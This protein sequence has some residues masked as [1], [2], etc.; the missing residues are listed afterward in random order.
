VLTAEGTT[1]GTLSIPG[2]FTEDGVNILVS[3]EGTFTQSGN[4]IT[5]EQEGDS[6]VPEVVWTIGPLG[7][8]TGIDT[9]PEGTIEVT[10]TRS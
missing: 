1:S 5:L 6:F 7:T 9:Q 8:L 10:L 2:T 3:M 4:T